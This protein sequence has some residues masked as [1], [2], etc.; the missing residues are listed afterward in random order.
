MPPATYPDRLTFYKISNNEDGDIEQVI[1]QI[2]QAA[3][4]MDEMPSDEYEN[5]IGSNLALGFTEIIENYLE[6]SIMPHVKYRS[7]ALTSLAT[8]G[9]TPLSSCMG[10]NGIYARAL[11]SP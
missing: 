3:K 5:S 8:P 7:I 4:L 1:S 6:N 10:F 2:V 9:H 11:I